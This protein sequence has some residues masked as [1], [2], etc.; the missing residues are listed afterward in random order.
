MHYGITLWPYFS[1]AL[2]KYSDKLLSLTEETI[3]CAPSHVITHY[4]FVCV[5]ERY[6]E[7]LHVKK[8]ADLVTVYKFI[9][10]L[11]FE[12]SSFRPPTSG[13]SDYSAG[14]VVKLKSCF[15]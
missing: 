3:P 13:I 14:N 15:L 6:T 1:V 11:T 10:L 9:T 12:L 7:T 2:V 8:M 5:T 4:R